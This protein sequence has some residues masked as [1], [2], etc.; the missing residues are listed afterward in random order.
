MQWLLR[1]IRLGM[2]LG[3]RTLN[4]HHLILGCLNGLVLLWTPFSYNVL[5][6]S[7]HLF[8]CKTLN[9]IVIV[10]GRGLPLVLHVLREYHIIIL[11]N[12]VVIESFFLHL[13]YVGVR[14]DF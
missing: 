14:K 7:Y 2:L 13:A 12:I 10:L 5:V 3:A 8:H 9:K 1:I 11:V 4:A 6:P